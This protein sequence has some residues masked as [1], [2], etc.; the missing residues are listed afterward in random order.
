MRY[1]ELLTE[2]FFKDVILHPWAAK[3]TSV[4][5]DDLSE[6]ITIECDPD[7]QSCAHA[8]GDEATMLDEAPQ[9]PLEAKY[10]EFNNKLFGGAL[11]EVNLQFAPLQG[12]S[13]TVTYRVASPVAVRENVAA[14]TFKPDARGRVCDPS[15][16]TLTMDSSLNRTERNYDA[17]LLHEMIHVSLATTG[18]FDDN[19]GPKFR[20]MATRLGQRVGFTIPIVDRPE[21]VAPNS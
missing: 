12:K 5:H 6:T 13:G 9:Y 11:P 2:D 21:V 7:C 3:R 16:L 8:D 1:R 4:T 20:A 14:P 18:D 17:V 15:S 10:R 19:H